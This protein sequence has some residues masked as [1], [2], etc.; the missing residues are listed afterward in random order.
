[1]IPSSRDLVL[2]RVRSALVARSPEDNAALVARMVVGQTWT[3]PTFD[4]DDVQ[5]FIEKAK[6]NLSSVETVTTLSDIGDAVDAILA[7]HDAGRDVSI[8]PELR[9]L[10]WPEKWT[11][12]FGAGRRRE[13][14]AITD[15]TA[16]IAET[17]SIV[18]CSEA[19][20]PAG[21][22]FVPELH[23]AIL[24]K[25]DIVHHLEDIWPK[26]RAMP[27]WPRAV[28]IISAASRTADVAQIVVRPAHGPKVLHIVLVEDAR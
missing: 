17:G 22:N 14:V 19:G 13:R 9:Y 11:I 2:G 3:R 23:V 21:L 12:H 20:R 15:A 24:H 26:V 8:A 18:M 1:M 7:H 27:V 16:G 6:A 25:S 4:G 28:N 5:R 10:R